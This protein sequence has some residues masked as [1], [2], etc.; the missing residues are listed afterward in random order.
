[1]RQE[2]IGGLSAHPKVLPCAYFYDAEGSTLYERITQLEE[3]YLTRTEAALLHAIAG[4]IADRAGPREIAELGAGSAS[5][6]RILLSEYARRS[7][8]I[9]FRPL[10]VSAAM[11]DLAVTGLTE[12]FPGAE[13]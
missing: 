10:D 13:I 8:P 9:L 4:E 7:W 3:Y 2:L 11:H 6:T 1:M 5:K 12:S